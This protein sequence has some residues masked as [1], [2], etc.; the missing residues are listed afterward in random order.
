MLFPN[1]SRF[2]NTI[3]RPLVGLRRPLHLVPLIP[4]PGPQIVPRHVK[5]PP[6]VRRGPVLGTD[7]P[8]AKNKPPPGLYRNVGIEP[9][10]QEAVAILTAPVNPDDLDID[11]AKGWLYMKEQAY[12]DRLNRAFG[13][14]GWELLPITEFWATDTRQVAFR[15]YALLVNGRFISEAIGDCSIAKSEPQEYAERRCEYVALLRTCKDVGVASELWDRSVANRLK[16]KYF[17]FKQDEQK[18]WAWQR[19]TTAQ[20]S[21]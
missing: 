11:P 8:D 15:T 21:W 16:K 17:E 10:P 9:F 3:R 2:V 14:E 7:L 13:E 12:R 6:I 19:R 20:R 4:S 18:K 5:P 1:R